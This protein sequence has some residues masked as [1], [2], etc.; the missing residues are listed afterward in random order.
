M[1]EVIGQRKRGR[2]KEALRLE[3]EKLAATVTAAAGEKSV[4]VELVPGEGRKKGESV[5]FSIP[6]GAVLAPFS[7]TKE[8]KDENVREQMR[9]AAK[10]A[11]RKDLTVRST[12]IR[13]DSGDE[14]TVWHFQTK[15]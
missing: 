1:A 7:L 15:E 14:V 9:L 3:L 12:G 10:D 6:K 8:K 11:G 13:L 5:T 2:K 4:T